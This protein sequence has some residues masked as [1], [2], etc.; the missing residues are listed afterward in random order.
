MHFQ[1]IIHIFTE[2]NLVILLQSL[3]K[4][5]VVKEKQALSTK[6]RWKYAPSPNIV[7]YEHLLTPLVRG[8][9]YQ[10]ISVDCLCRVIKRA[11]IVL[12][13]LLT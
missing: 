8:N 9:Q 13:Q 11:M 12:T 7:F 2:Y 5:L 10:C 1:I 6:R 4:L 3:T